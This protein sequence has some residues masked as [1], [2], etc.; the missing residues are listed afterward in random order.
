MRA[1]YLPSLIVMASLLAFCVSCSKPTI[2]KRELTPAEQVWNQAEGH[3]RTN[4]L[5][6]AYRL[7][8]GAENQ[9]DRMW[10][11]GKGGLDY[12]FC[13]AIMNGQLFLMARA[14]GHTN[15]AEDFVA[16]SEFHFNEERSKEHL[17]QTNFSA[18][19]IEALIREWDASL[20][21]GATNRANDKPQH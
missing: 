17:P 5:H 20:I 2:S 16:A 19:T 4:E 3:Y 12:N 18:A 11:T 7:M 10:R 14:L 1:N 6:E 15:E 21:S 13:L 9:L 8:L